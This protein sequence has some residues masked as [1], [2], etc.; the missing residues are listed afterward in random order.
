[1]ATKL[2]TKIDSPASSVLESHQHLVNM[3]DD[4]N[5]LPQGSRVRAFDFEAP[6]H[7]IH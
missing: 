5:P 7:H 6:A 1:M 4:L 2:A 3:A